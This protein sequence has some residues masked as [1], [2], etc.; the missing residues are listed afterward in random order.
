M[1]LQFDPPVT[2]R[3]ARWTVMACF[4]L[5]PSLVMGIVKTADMEEGY[6]QEEPDELSVLL[7]ST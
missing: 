2:I 3:Y 7:Q 1:F 5:L 6:E 4:A